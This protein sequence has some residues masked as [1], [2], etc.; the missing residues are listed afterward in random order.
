MR[1]EVQDFF[2][3]L[4]YISVRMQNQDYCVQKLPGGFA[5]GSSEVAHFGL[6]LLQVTPK[7]FGQKLKTT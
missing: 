6:P 2:L 3:C 7:N 5:S 4:G 1:N